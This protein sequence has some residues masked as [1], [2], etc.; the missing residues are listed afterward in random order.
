NLDL[1]AVNDVLDVP[2]QNLPP[3]S[4]YVLVTYT[5]ARTGTFDVFNAP[6][7]T[8]NYDDPN[9]RITVTSVPEPATIALVSFTA[10]S[11]LSRRRNRRRSVSDSLAPVIGGEGYGEGGF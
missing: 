2:N 5:G 9:K 1:S 4:T 11:L 10:L 7:Y 3:A 6:F 8:I